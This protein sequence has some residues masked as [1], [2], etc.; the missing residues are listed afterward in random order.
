M[1]R[2]GRWR[3]VA[4]VIALAGVLAA[5]AA[6]GVGVLST[7]DV[8]APPPSIIEGDPLKAAHGRPV[9]PPAGE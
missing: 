4:L 9:E 8:A 7:W 5:I 6:L 1:E 2:P 3:D